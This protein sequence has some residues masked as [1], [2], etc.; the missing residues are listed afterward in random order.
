MRLSTEWSR[1]IPQSEWE[2]YR[3]ILDDALRLQIPFAL[4]GAFAVA[5]YT[6]SWRNTKDLDLYVMPQ[7]PERMIAVL[8]RHGF[9][10]YFNIRPYDRWW[11][12]R[13][14]KQGMIVDV[15]WATANHRTEVK[16]SWIS[17]PEVEVRGRSLRVLPVEILVQ[18]KLYIL[19]RERCDWPDVL[20]LI[21][22]RG[23][24]IDW[25]GLL[26]EMKD[27]QPLLA[28][29]LAVFA[30]I[31]PGRA[32]DLPAWLWRRLGLEAPARSAGP[33]I[34]ASRV[35]LMDRRPWFGPDRETQKPAA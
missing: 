32:Q 22:S 5:A 29:V 13:G 8:S 9:A 27:D 28:G 31:A 26:R 25:E 33:G 2:A 19:Q 18:D 17:G 30:W 7:Q 10:D 12:Y 3:P 35:N 1:G 11:I 24:G 4:G 14:F 20:N 16:E 23:D 6:G 34:L 15:I 21:Y